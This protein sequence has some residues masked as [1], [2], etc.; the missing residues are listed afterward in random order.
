[1]TTLTRALTLVLLTGCLVSWSPNWHL[2]QA[3]TVPPTTGYV[4]DFADLLEPSAEETL[5]T[6][7]NATAEKSGAE[8]RVVTLQSLEGEPPA[9][10]ARQLF[11]EW[12]IGQKDQPIGVMLL[13]GV[14]DQALEIITSQGDQPALAE[15]FK[16]TVIQQKIAP[17]FNSTD[18]RA[19]IQ[20]GINSILLYLDNPDSILISNID[21]TS[22]P[23][24][25]TVFSRFVLVLGLY[26]V[27]AASVVGVASA[28]A[29][30]GRSL[31]IWPASVV[32]AGL[33]F[34]LG[35]LSQVGLLAALVFGLL[36]LGLEYVI[37]SRF[38]S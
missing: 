12:Q 15:N 19:G 10:V 32:A 29:Y 24:F 23:A 2:A 33:G 20:A 21:G 22:A 26:T 4:N 6:Q 25:E 30:F 17:S 14:D 7:L 13:V 36:Q 5:E 8:V 27:L 37:R 31:P 1:M 18:Y 16:Q 28:V 35:W 34:A 38:S 3:L 11:Q 9:E